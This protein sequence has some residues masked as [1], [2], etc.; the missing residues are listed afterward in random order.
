VGEVFDPNPLLCDPSEKAAIEVRNGVEQ[1]RYLDYLVSE[2]GATELRESFVLELQQIAV[3]DIYP[4]GGKYRTVLQRVRI[5]NSPHQIPEPA[6]VQALTQEAVDLINGQR[7]E[8]SALD[9]AAY[10]LWR[11][12]WIHPFAGGNGR[13]SRC[14][15]YLIVCMDAGRILP[16][17]VTMPTLIYDERDAYIKALRDVDASVSAD[18]SFNIKPMADFLRMMLVK[19]LA[20]AVHALSSPPSVPNSRV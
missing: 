7:K 6:F 9:R 5:S 1:L 8:R 13:T 3:K 17:D 10:A 4:C 2:R 11:F 18:G 15:A 14:V 16:G 12:N 20:Q 19:Q